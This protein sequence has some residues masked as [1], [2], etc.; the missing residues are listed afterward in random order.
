MTQSDNKIDVLCGI[1]A[2]ITSIVWA[3]IIYLIFI[4]TPL[5]S[6]RELFS[7]G[8][9][10]LALIAPTYYF[11]KY[12]IF[13]K[14]HGYTRRKK[15]ILA[16]ATI[17]FGVFIAFNAYH[18]SFYLLYPNHKLTINIP[19]AVGPDAGKRMIAITWF[20][21]GWGDVSFS[22]FG[23]TGSWRREPN[24]IFHT[25]G[26]PASL[27]WSGIIKDI[28]TIEFEK[29]PNAGEIEVIWDGQTSKYD[30][31][32]T[33]NEKVIAST[34][35]NNYHENALERIIYFLGFGAFFLLMT[36]A[37]L[38]IRI[39]GT[40]ELKHK[41]FYWLL[42]P[43]PMIAVW[44]FFLLLVFPGKV[45]EDS[46]VQWQ[47][48]ISN[49]YTD[50]HPIPYAL[51]MALVSRVYPF[52][53]SVALAQILMV[54]LAFAWG[55]DAL[56][57]MRVPRSI[58]WGLSVLM[59]VLPVNILSTIVLRKDVPYST[60]IL[61]LSII[62]L[63]IIISKGEWLQHGWNWL[64]LGFT[65]GMVSLFRLNGFPVV[66]G[67]VFLLL[68]FY[69]QK[70]RKILAATGV[71]ILLTAVLYG[72][73][74][75]LLKVK[76][77]PEFGSILFLHHIAAHIKAGT[78]LSSDEESFLNQIA[79]L[80]SWE[81]S[82]CSNLPTVFSLFP[83]S[84]AI[85]NY[86]LPFL[87][88]NINTPPK[89]AEE[90][91]LKN[92]LV[93]LK[94]ISCMGQII[95]S[96]NSSCP[97]YTSIEFFESDMVNSPLSKINLP[98]R[99]ISFFFHILPNPRRNPPFMEYHD[100]NLVMS[101]YLYLAVYAVTIFSIRQKNWRFVFFLA[102]VLIHSVTL[103][104]INYSQAYR[105]QYGVALVGMLSIGLLF[106]AQRNNSA[107]STSTYKFRPHNFFR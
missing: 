65:F 18:P 76:H 3:S 50:H 1:A 73:V 49:N 77:E 26:T 105:Y 89:I 17:L 90:L 9:I 72:P 70:W 107:E 29:S 19:G 78:I 98:P 106:V 54:S 71:F 35:L 97:D 67:V 96:V 84:P 82:C 5:V 68:I 2:I 58:L 43:L 87:R 88:Q 46:W 48:V 102:P 41:R 7:A 83:N 79:P 14:L 39:Q 40:D 59:A 32:G 91:F 53:A 24:K 11:L 44:L 69:F 85:Q 101:M 42:Y 15:I 62:F 23:Q 20:R 74:Y 52:P 64:G 16:L 10:F 27:Q 38:E 63:K 51:L 94:H 30:L 12:L 100:I 103:F 60:G 61:L 81:Y 13:P 86:D 104:I 22:Q 31:T 28:P 55:L 45:P 66:I 80:S 4:Q 47:Q 99:I 92:P 34:E 93:D 95:F 8:V 75:S 56:E 25:G 37:F 36:I 57:E 21:N 6:K 33:A